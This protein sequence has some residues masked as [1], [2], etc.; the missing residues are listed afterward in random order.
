MNYLAHLY[1]A[2]PEPDALLGALM[3]DFVKGPV[4]GYP[5]PIER[6]L[7]LHRRIDTF[8]DTHPRVQASRARI[9][10]LRRRFAGI[11]LDLFYDHY[12][13]RYWDEYSSDPLDVF[14]RR[15][16]A[17]LRVHHAQLPPRLQAV[18]PRMAQTDWLASYRHVDSVHVALDRISQRLKRAN[19]L[20]GAGH[21]LEANYR[22]LEEDFRAFFPDVVRFAVEQRSG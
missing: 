6:A 11:M 12:L 13:A 4:R 16:Y 22:A 10:P 5:P 8:T 7:I 2:G 21:E 18:A 15:I 1:L 19:R 3:G 20:G 17:L 9:S 14:T